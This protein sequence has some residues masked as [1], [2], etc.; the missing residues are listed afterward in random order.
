[1]SLEHAF[2]FYAVPRKGAD[3]D[4]P[5]SS[6]PKKVVFISDGNENYL[7]FE[8]VIVRFDFGVRFVVPRQ[9]VN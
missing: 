5:V 8:G 3:P 2:T 1:M 9:E 6:F 4:A 7:R